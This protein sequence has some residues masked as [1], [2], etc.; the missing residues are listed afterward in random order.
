MKSLF[1]PKTLWQKFHRRRDLLRVKT[2]T[3]DP[4]QD[5]STIRDIDT[6]DCMSQESARIR[7]ITRIAQ[8]RLQAE[9]IENRL[10]H[11]LQEENLG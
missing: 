11:V 9:Q 3:E 4:N 1:N 6:T 5:K 8:A 10:R 2:R 7:L